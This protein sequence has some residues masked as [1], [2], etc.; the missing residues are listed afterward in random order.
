MVTNGACIVFCI[1]SFLIGGW[2]SLVVLSLCAV[3]KDRKSEERE[4]ENR[5]D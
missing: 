2:I 4:N 1:I 3:A 5:V